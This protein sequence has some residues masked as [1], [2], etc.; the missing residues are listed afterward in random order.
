MKLPEYNNRPSNAPL[1]SQKETP[2]F[3]G[4]KFLLLGIGL[5]VGIAACALIAV[6]SL[7]QALT[8]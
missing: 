5:P 8:H 3:E 6:V 1:Y 7:F 2:P 4:I